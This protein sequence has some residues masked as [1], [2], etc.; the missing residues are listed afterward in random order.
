MAGD[1]GTPVYDIIIPQ[2]ST[3]TLQITWRDSANA[4]INLTGYTARMMARTEAAATATIFSLTS[5]SE[6]TLG[7][8]AGT[9]LITIPAAS[10]LALTAGDYV[11]DLEVVSGGGLVYRLVKGRCTVDAE[12]TR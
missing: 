6:I 4:L 3:Y 1:N 9:V 8:V 12:V 11:Y 2:G 7:G 10:T 5:A